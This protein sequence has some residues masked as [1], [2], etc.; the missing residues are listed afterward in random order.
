VRPLKLVIEL[1]APLLANPAMLAPEGMVTVPVKVGLAI[2][3]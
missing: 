1:L 2:G 3:A